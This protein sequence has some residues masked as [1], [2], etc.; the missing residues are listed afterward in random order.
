MRW[1]RG[2]EETIIVNEA[3]VKSAGWKGSPVGRYVQF[4]E[5]KWR[6]IGLIKDFH[7]ESLFEKLRPLVLFFNE[8]R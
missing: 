3:F 4:G 7:F 1:E 2:E 6:I 8:E 5:K